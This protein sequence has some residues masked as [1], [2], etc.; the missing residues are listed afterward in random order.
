MTVRAA[1]AAV[2]TLG[3]AGRDR[4]ALR[5]GGAVGTGLAGGTGRGVARAVSTTHLDAG[6]ARDDG[7]VHGRRSVTLVGV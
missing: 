3:T 4:G 7:A 5:P 6:H 1:S 2:V